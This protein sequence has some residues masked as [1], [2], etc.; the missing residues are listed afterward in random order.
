MVADD[1]PVL[2]D[3]DALGIGLDLHRPADG[4]RHDAVPVVIEPHEARL[5][6]RADLDA[7]PIKRAP[8][9]DQ[10]GAFRLEHLKDRALGLIGMRLTASRGDTLI[11]QPR[12]ELA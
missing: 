1:R 9:R 6:H 4:P 11:K 3:H 2:A 5:G 10:R 7:A 8:V 12:I